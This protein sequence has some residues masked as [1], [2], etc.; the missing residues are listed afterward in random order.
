VD[1]Y[2]CATEMCRNRGKIWPGLDSFKIHI[3]RMHRDEDEHDLILRSVRSH[4]PQRPHPPPLASEQKKTFSITTPSIPFLEKYHE[5]FSDKDYYLGLESPPGKVP[6]PYVSITLSHFLGTPRVFQYGHLSSIPGEDLKPNVQF[7]SGYGSLPASKPRVI[8]QDDDTVS[9]RSIVTKGSRLYLPR[10]EE[11]H[12]ICAFTGDLCQDIDPR[13][14]IDVSGQ[15]IAHL[16]N[17]LRTF[18][19]KLARYITCKAESDAAEF[20]RQQRKYVS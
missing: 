20:L 6:A 12:L 2:Q 8:Q 15:V 7:D 17:L 1:D 10:D 19:M 9:V 13:G 16:P 5:E 3:N 14:D 11:E 4:T 18:A